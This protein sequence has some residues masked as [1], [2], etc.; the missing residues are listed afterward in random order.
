MNRTLFAKELRANLFVSLII[1]AVLA[2]YIGVIVSMYDPE[3]GESLDAMMQS[4]PELF[5]A[6]GMATQTSTLVDFLL[7]YLYGFLLT[8][9][10]F[11]FILIVVNKLVVKPVD[12]G[13]MA[14][15]LATPNS[16]T[17]I[18]VT[19]AA[20]LVALLALLLA[21]TI[22]SEFLCAELMFPGELDG[23]ALMRANAGLFALWLFLAGMCFL[24]ACL[25]S[26]A[27]RALW[28]GGGLGV[29]FFL[30]Q[31]VAQVG[32]R[33]EFLDSINPLMLYDAY[34]LAAGE[35]SA[36]AGASA[37]LVAGVALFAIAAAVFNRRDLSL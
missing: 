10:P 14:Y 32:D 28:V 17:R 7:N 37:L 26:S 35:G 20:A 22:G 19:L 9:M 12:R 27:G 5:A 2:M 13:T 31:M 16:R 8:L 11:A 3:L 21:I 29:L 4:M 25:F 23:Q 34:G 24:S 18:V 33:F 15:L 36:F 1:A 30:M 6:F